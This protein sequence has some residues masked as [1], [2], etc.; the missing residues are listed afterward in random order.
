MEAAS[1]E[2]RRS[3]PPKPPLTRRCEAARGPAAPVARGPV[4]LPLTPLMRRSEV[5]R[6]LATLLLR[7]RCEAPS[8]AARK[9]LP[10]AAAGPACAEPRRL[11][12]ALPGVELVELPEADWCCG[13]AG[14]YTLLRPE[15]A[16]RLLAHKVRHVRETCADVLVTANPPCLMQIGRG[17]ARDGS[18]VKLVHLAEFLDSFWP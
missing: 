3:A 15:M 2:A 7:R 12:K 18:P 9:L 6:G 17:L 16:D 8:A 11:L 5:A 13:G 4:A 10:P 14:S 1:S